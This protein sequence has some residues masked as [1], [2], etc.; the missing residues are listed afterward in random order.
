MKEKKC[1]I[2]FPLEC[3]IKVLAVLTFLGTATLVFESYM[4]DGMFS[5]YW[6][7]IATCG[8]MF[9]CWIYTFALPTAQN[10]RMA[11]LAWIV[12]VVIVGRISYLAIILNGSATD[13]YCEEHDIEKY[14]EVLNRQEIITIE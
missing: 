5:L 4:N 1:C 3:G 7:Q 9:L 12:L 2:C 11:H 10:R 13:F 14:N 6:P 8:A